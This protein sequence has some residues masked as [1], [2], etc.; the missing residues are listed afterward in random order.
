MQ[1]NVNYDHDKW[2]Q[3][4]KRLCEE[5]IKGK[6]LQNASLR[7]LLLSTK[8]KTLAECCSDK[9]WGTGVPLYDDK[10]LDHSVWNSQGILGEILELVRSYIIDILGT[11]KESDMVS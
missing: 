7:D 3:N 10:C 1:W 11:N 9:L 4:A 6:F 8:N 5:G 2:V